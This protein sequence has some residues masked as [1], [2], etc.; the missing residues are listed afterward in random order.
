M[1]YTKHRTVGCGFHC[2]KTQ[3]QTSPEKAAD[4]VSRKCSTPQ[5]G[6]RMDFSIFKPTERKTKN[7]SEK[8]FIADKQSC[9]KRVIELFCSPQGQ[10]QTNEQTDPKENKEEKQGKEERDVQKGGRTIQDVTGAMKWL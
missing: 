4:R 5:S 1:L 3:T 8:V 2:A 7:V 6:S 9:Q 10:R